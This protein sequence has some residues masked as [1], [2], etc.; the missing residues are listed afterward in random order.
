M[1]A[2]GCPSRRGEEYRVR[3]GFQK[4]RMRDIVRAQK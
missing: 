1:R 4:A 3:R 2:L